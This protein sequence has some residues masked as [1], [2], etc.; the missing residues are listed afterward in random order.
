LSQLSV[1]ATEVALGLTQ[2]ADKMSAA[3]VRVMSSL[4]NA[5]G[6]LGFAV[7][8]AVLG[9]VA[10][11]RVFISLALFAGLG[12]SDQTPATVGFSVFYLLSG[13]VNADLSLLLFALAFAYTSVEQ[14]R[15][16]KCLLGVSVS[17]AFL[18]SCVIVGL[19]GHQ[20][21]LRVILPI[22][23]IILT[24][25]VLVGFIALRIGLAQI[26]SLSAFSLLPSTPQGRV[27]PVVPLAIHE[28]EHLPLFS[29]QQ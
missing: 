4:P 27:K 15:A 16:K 14:V 5:P 9:L 1:S 18:F 2:Q 12:P 21:A 19:A 24:C 13:L 6:G 25:W 10:V 11:L 22:E 28:S 17:L 23:L 7:A 3:L 29:P 20:T 8:G 26:E